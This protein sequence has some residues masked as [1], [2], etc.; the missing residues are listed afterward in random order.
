MVL[1]PFR[2]LS[3]FSSVLCRCVLFSLSLC[4]SPCTKLPEPH[5]HCIAMFFFA[6]RHPR[7]PS[8][9][10]LT[11]FTS[12]RPRRNSWMA[13]I[14]CRRGFKKKGDVRYSLLNSTILQNILKTYH[15]I[16]HQS[17]QCAC[18][19]ICVRGFA[20]TVFRGT[21]PTVPLKNQV[22]RLSVASI[23]A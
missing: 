1:L 7:V 21:W 19:Q 14:Q 5:A 3:V 8:D 11:E 18:I 20:C 22:N 15:I 9:R 17:V 23:D 4:L 13:T 12:V 10:S 6:N 2:C 16:S